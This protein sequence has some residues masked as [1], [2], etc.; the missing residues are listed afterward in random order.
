MAKTRGDRI[1]ELSQLAEM[2]PFP[3]LG[4]LQ[5]RAARAVRK[6]FAPRRKKKPAKRK[7]K[8]ARRA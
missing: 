8:R 5:Q 7:R 6:S 3:G 1:A 4:E 2:T